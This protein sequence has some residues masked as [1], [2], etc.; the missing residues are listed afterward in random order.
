MGQGVSFLQCDQKKSP[1]VD[2][3]CPKLIS[4]EKW[5]I[6]T[7]IQKLPK[8]VGDLGKLIVAKGFKKLPKVPKIAQSG[9]TAFLVPILL[10]SLN[11]TNKTKS[12]RG[13]TRLQKGKCQSIQYC[14]TLT[15]F[16]VN[17]YTSRY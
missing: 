15:S 2:K 12:I 1:N 9:H 4:L 5:T 6:L 17:F 16:S 3:Y 8:N 7:P 14:S 13:L 11:D 10:R